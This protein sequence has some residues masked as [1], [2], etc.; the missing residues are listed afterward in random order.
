ML[1]LWLRINSKVRHQP[2]LNMADAPRISRI[3]LSP[4][5]LFA[6]TSVYSRY[7]ARVGTVLFIPYCS[8]EY[9]LFAKSDRSSRRPSL[10]RSI[11][12]SKIIFPP[13]RNIH[14]QFAIAISHPL[15]SRRLRPFSLPPIMTAYVCAEITPT[16]APQLPSPKPIPSAYSPA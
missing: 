12:L 5:G 8:S 6:F 14:R 7:M 2:W 15:H 13:V 4:L 16:P 9:L 11:L 1:V 10:G 3:L